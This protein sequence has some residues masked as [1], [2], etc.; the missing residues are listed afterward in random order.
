MTQ[1]E[2]EHDDC[3]KIVSYEPYNMNR[4][5]STG[6]GQI[7]YLLTSGHDSI[8]LSMILSSSVLF[9]LSY[10]HFLQTFF[11]NYPEPLTYPLKTENNWYSRYLYRCFESLLLFFDRVNTSFTIRFKIYAAH[12]PQPLWESPRRVTKCT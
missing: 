10:L 3:T 4:I 5:P 7:V 12:P 11:P 8:L 9:F 6:H 2:V 1:K